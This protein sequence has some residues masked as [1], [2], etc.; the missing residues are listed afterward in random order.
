L[1]TPEG[2]PRGTDPLYSSARGLGEPQEP[3]WLLWRKQNLA[4]AEI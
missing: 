1:H 3:T 4:T 2:I